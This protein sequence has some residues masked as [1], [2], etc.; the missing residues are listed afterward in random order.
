[1]A[2]KD[3]DKKKSLFIIGPT[4]D[5]GLEQRRGQI[6]DAVK[7]GDFSTAELARDSA[8]HQSTILRDCYKLREKGQISSYHQEYT[9]LSFPMTGEIM[10]SA[11]HDRLRELDRKLKAIFNKHM[12]GTRALNTALRKFFKGLR[13][14]SD[15]AKYR[16]RIA[17]FEERLFA[18]LPEA[19]ISPKTIS[20]IAGCRK[21]DAKEVLGSA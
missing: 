1:M 19:K 21:I 16:S 5:V 17:D 3:K 20:K 11:N 12:L 14:R 15:L 8:Y 13:K 10:Q 18:A 9:L 2:K 4:K 7:S 6:I